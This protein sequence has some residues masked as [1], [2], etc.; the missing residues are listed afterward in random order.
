MIL[1]GIKYQKYTSEN[2]L[3]VLT[4]LYM[5]YIWYLDIFWGSKSVFYLYLIPVKGWV[6]L[7]YFVPRKLI[8]RHDTNQG[9]KSW[10]V[11]E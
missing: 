10:G 11:E 3:Q 8:W 2:E 4:C 7:L 1:N 5:V 6:R 9:E